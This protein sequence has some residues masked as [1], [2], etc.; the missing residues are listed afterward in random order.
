MSEAAPP[1]LD[2]LLARR[3]WVRRFAR[4]LA[5]DDA[6]ADDLAQDAWV[7][8]VERPPSSVEA[9]TGWLRRVLTRR[10][11][12]ASRERERRQRREIGASRPEATQ[13]AADVVAAAES[14]RRVVEAVMELDEPYRATVLLRFFE[15]LSP[16]EVAAR[17]GVPVE[18][19]RA[20]VRRAV[21]KLRT[22]LDEKHGGRRAAW[23]AP[24]LKGTPDEVGPR[25]GAAATGGL[26]MTTTQKTV[27]ACV[28]LLLVLGAGLLFSSSAGRETV[29]A[30]TAGRAEESDEPSAPRRG[31]GG[32]STAAAAPAARG[33]QSDRATPPAAPDPTASTSK[34][35]FHHLD[36][37]VV[38]SSR[39]PID[40][41]RVRISVNDNG[42]KPPPEQDLVGVTDERG[43]FHFKVDRPIR[44]ASVDFVGADGR[45]WRPR[46][47]WMA[48]AEAA[49]RVELVVER[50]AWIAG[51]VVL[52][53]GAPFPMAPI[54]ALERGRRVASTVTDL[55]GRFKLVVP[56]E[57]AWDVVIEAI[58]PGQ[59]R[60][61]RVGHAIARE[62]RP[63]D[64]PS[65]ERPSELS[66]EARGVASGTQDVAIT[67]TRRTGTRT[68]RVRAVTTDGRPVAGV[69][70]RLVGVG[71]RGEFASA[72]RTGED[73]RVDILE[74]PDR[75]ILASFWGDGP[76]APQ[77]ERDGWI[78][79]SLSL[80]TP[81]GDEEFVIELV[82]G[83]P[84][85]GRVE[86]P[87]GFEPVKDARGRAARASISV[88]DESTQ[89]V[90]TCRSDPDGRFTAL[91]P[92]DAAG[93]F[94][95]LASFSG[96]GTML[97]ARIDEVRAD[98]EDVVVRFTAK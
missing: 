53:D 78:V 2:V 59:N 76:E 17:M 34:Q 92:A 71:R 81:V 49:E 35:R 11:I 73:G 87:E 82:P 28:M 68:L 36:V 30:R 86:T 64:T 44:S 25:T 5:R 31:R 9:P 38:D 77:W 58:D 80:L 21:D 60:I 69:P 26:A 63:A 48:S 93:P 16:R 51:R 33:A 8:A 3:E 7:T 79:P 89:R 6:S 83:R 37:C 32:R 15:D 98:A 50:A 20:R 85:R 23:L 62:D 94:T 70:I 42:F 46:R 74:V 84:I 75:R 65:V 54:S 45:A 43:R 24:L 55:D 52:E 72:P 4:T 40:G 61:T 91:V 29:G 90:W 39:T 22:R 57:G 96:V 88:S 14:H 10:A 12:D 66:G 19:V 47:P 1:P 95:L 27:A 56:A 41:A 67:A 18:T 97:Q 13:S